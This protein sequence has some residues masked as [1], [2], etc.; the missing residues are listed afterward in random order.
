MG[1]IAAM[2]GLA[3]ALHALTP[4]PAELA[5]ALS[6]P[7][8]TADTAGP[9]VLV[10][11]LAGVLAWIVWAWGALGLLLTAATALPGLVGAAAHGV[12]TV[13]LPAGARRSAAVLLG[14]GVGVAAPLL[15]ALPAFGPSISAAAAPAVSPVPDWPAAVPVGV[16][17]PDWPAAPLP[18]PDQPAPD[19]PAVAPPAAEPVP[20][21]PELGDSQG[22]VV[23]RGDSLWHIATAWLQDRQG[24]VPTDGEVAGAVR[25]WWTANADVI[26]P[27]PDLL[28]P[29][30]VLHPPQ[31]P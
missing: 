19:Q 11:A 15:P 18:A 26:G 2:A 4:A 28:L 22:H 24:G 14:L 31:R 6:A 25:Q 13:L 27:E 8:R 5:A 21:W 10:L 12:L 23:V 29:G 17:A 16:P 20:D 9:D 30:Q 1:T 7:Q 3:L